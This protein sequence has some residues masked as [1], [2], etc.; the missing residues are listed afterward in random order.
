MTKTV[1]IVQVPSTYTTEQKQ[2]LELQVNRVVETGGAI[3]L[4]YDVDVFSLPVGD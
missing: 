1:V 3:I 4:P 2:D